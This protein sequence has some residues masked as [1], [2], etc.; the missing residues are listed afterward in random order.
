MSERTSDIHNNIHSNELHQP[1]DV[2]IEKDIKKDFFHSRRLIRYT[3]PNY[4][5]KVQALKERKAIFKRIQEK[6]RN[7][8]RKHK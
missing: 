8:T 1:K 2:S 3:L 7:N 4:Y 5:R 6:L